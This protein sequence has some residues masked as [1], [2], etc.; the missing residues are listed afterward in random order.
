MYT[1]TPSCIFMMDALLVN[2]H[3]AQIG[4]CT[5]APVT[6]HPSAHAQGLRVSTGIAPGLLLFGD[7]HCHCPLL[8]HWQASS[9]CEKALACSGKCVHA[10]KPWHVP[11]KRTPCQIVSEFLHGKPMQNT[12][13]GAIATSWYTKSGANQ[14][15]CTKVNWLVV[16]KFGLLCQPCHNVPG[17]LE[18]WCQHNLFMPLNTYPNSKKQHLQSPLPR[19]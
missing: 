13:F 5:V 1:G 12:V 18:A 19:I 10:T 3:Q 14:F 8:V 17:A 11:Y 16:Q 7:C 6:P 2:A 15:L 9:S 4:E